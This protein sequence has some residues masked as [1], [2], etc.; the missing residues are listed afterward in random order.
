MVLKW[1]VKE[2]NVEVRR[3]WGWLTFKQGSALLYCLGQAQGG[4][5][6]VLLPKGRARLAL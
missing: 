4:L 1:N 3:Q 5:S 2:G 6:G